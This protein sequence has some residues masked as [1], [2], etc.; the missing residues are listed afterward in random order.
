MRG[1]HFLDSS[2]VGG[3][4][5]FDEGVLVVDMCLE[6]GEVFLLHAGGRS[7]E[8]AEKGD[9]KDDA[10]EEGGDEGTGVA[11]EMKEDI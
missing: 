3:T 8:E 7:G 9:E 6:S 11:R 5:L 4:H 2:L 10:E 1:A